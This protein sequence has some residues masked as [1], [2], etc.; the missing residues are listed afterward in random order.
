VST[1]TKWEYGIY[2]IVL[3]AFL[4]IMVHDVHQLLQSTQAVRGVL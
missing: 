1:R 4:A 3:A 2:Y